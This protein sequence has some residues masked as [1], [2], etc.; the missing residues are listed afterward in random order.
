MQH[1]KHHI[2]PEVWNIIQAA[3]D[4][5]RLE[6]IRSFM[7]IFPIIEPLDRPVLQPAHIHSPPIHQHQSPDYTPIPMSDFHHQNSIPPKVWDL[8]QRAPPADRSELLFAF[9]KATAPYN[10][11]HSNQP[12]SPSSSFVPATP[13]S[14]SEEQIFPENSIS[15]VPNSPI[16]NIDTHDQVVNTFRNQHMVALWEAGNYRNKFHPAA[17]KVFQAISWADAVEQDCDK[18]EAWILI[19]YL[20][21]V[22][23][24]FEACFQVSQLFP[25]IAIPAKAPHIIASGWWVLTFHDCAMVLI[26]EHVGSIS[27]KASVVQDLHKRGRAVFQASQRAPVLLTNKIMVDVDEMVQILQGAGVLGFKYKSYAQKIPLYRL[28]AFDENILRAAG[29]R[30]LNLHLALSGWNQ[31]PSPGLNQYRYHP[32]AQDFVDLGGERVRI[33]ATNHRAFG[34]H[35]DDGGS[36]EIEFIGHPVLKKCWLYSHAIHWVKQ[37]TYV[38]PRR[39]GNNVSE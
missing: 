6:L 39:W 35:R 8:I 5:E 1:I 18:I 33:R 20:P 25:T 9:L 28:R 26:Q 4:S 29:N 13:I 24:Q 19:Q 12:L 16:S 38:A 37:A 32:M 23:V 7:S 22:I 11:S 2:P 27:V 36:V 31:P 34:L 21:E 17:A 15:L 14:P 10:Q 30:I 3:P